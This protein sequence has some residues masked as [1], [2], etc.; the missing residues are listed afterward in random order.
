MITRDEL[1]KVARTPG[2]CSLQE[3]RE[4]E[5]FLEQFQMHLSRYQDVYGNPEGMSVLMELQHIKRMQ[6]YVASSGQ[7]TVYT[8]EDNNDYTR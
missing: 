1:L 5:H 4:A 6:A 3:L 8:H 2:L 7:S